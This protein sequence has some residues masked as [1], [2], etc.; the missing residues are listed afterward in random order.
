LSAIDSCG[1][2]AT[3]VLGGALAIPDAVL[4]DLPKPTRLSG[5]D[6]YETCRLI[7]EASLAAGFSD[8]AV[9]LAIGANFPDALSA[10][11][12][13]AAR[14]IPVLLVRDPLPAPAITYATD[15]AGVLWEV[16]PVG[17]TVVVPE[18]VV[19]AFKDVLTD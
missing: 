1:V 7:A 15:H 6:R 3:T 13:S 16:I 19:T 11:A 17:G 14:G 2:T 9:Y 4:A 10:G 5:P 18:S 8:E 12:A